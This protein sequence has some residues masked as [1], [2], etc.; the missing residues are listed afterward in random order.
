MALGRNQGPA[1]MK[2][3]TGELCRTRGLQ[4]QA[5]DFFL[6]ALHFGT[7]RSFHLADA[8][9]IASRERDERA[10]QTKG[11]WAGGIACIT[12]KQEVCFQGANSTPPFPV[13]TKDNRAHASTAARDDEQR[14]PRQRTLS[15]ECKREP[16]IPMWTTTQLA[17]YALA[18][19]HLERPAELRTRMALPLQQHTLC[20]AAGRCRG[21]QCLTR[22]SN[23]PCV[24]Q[25]LCD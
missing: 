15:C 18:V 20:V 4:H 5:S 14:G 9:W 13:M 24:Q 19:R 22:Q 11:G 8:A 1:R 25:S 6:V 16:E 12:A 2:A 17:A 23:T 10:W 21:Q 3:G 7:A